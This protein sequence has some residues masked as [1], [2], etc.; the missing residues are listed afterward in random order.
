[1]DGMTDNTAEQI[2]WALMR[3]FGTT[4]IENWCYEFDME[5]DNED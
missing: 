5:Q 2:T 1:M 4:K 3:R